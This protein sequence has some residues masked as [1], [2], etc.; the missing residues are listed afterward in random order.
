MGGAL[1]VE[2]ER[3]VLAGDPNASAISWT[4]GVVA[5]AG[6]RPA[7]ITIIVIELSSLVVLGIIR[8]P[9]FP[10]DHELARADSDFGGC[11]YEI[12]PASSDDRNLAA[13]GGSS[14]RMS[15]T[16]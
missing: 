10:H 11:S 14:R 16:K 5:N 2:L 8:V 7:R 3:C 6:E 12:S 1:S 15:R 4:N 9:F 13:G